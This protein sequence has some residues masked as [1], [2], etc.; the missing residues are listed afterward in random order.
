[1]QSDAD[2]VRDALGGRPSAYG[3]LARRWAP[4]V[5]AVCHS[6]VRRGGAA[7]DLAQEAL[8]RGYAGLRT[9]S[10][11]ERFGAWLC[12]IAARACLDWLKAKA[13]TEVPFSVLSTEEGVEGLF[14]GK[15]EGPRG[16][17]QDDEVRRLLEEVEDLPEEYRK[18]IFLFYYDDMT[19]QEAAG[20]LGVSP[21]TVNARLTKARAMLRQRLLTNAR[22]HP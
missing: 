20:V 2:L 19:Y 14:P 22:R 8:L 3:E 7:E 13:R 1:M 18:V 4:R 15:D 11:P 17:E 12:G 10:D 6:K 21:A 9:L 5:L 16:V